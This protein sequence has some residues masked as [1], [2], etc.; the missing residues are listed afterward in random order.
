MIL[1]AFVR[2][3]IC[4][5]LNDEESQILMDQG[6][7][8]RLPQGEVLFNEGESGDSMYVILQGRLHIYQTLDGG[9]VKTVAVLGYGAILGEVTLIDR[10]VRTASAASMEDTALF[11]LNRSNVVS[12]IRA[13]PSLAAK[14]LWA[15]M[16]TVTVRLRDT[17]ASVQALLAEKLKDLPKMG[18]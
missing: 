15:I 5:Y 4:R 1:Q 14:V 6:R 8:R 17:N 13:H 7:L 10:Q 12:L 3:H 2:T 11:E 18:M 9:V 16:E